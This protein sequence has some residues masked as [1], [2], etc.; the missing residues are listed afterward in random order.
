MD[1]SLRFRSS[2][3]TKKKAMDGFQQFC[4][5]IKQNLSVAGYLHNTYC[6]SDMGILWHLF[7]GS[8]SVT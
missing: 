5:V 3:A 1:Y 7:Y 8:L 2:P 4:D 6:L